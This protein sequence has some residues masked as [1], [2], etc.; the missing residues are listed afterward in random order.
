MIVTRK[1]V[2]LTG[3]NFEQNRALPVLLL[4]QKR[5]GEDPATCCKVAEKSDY[6]YY[7]VL[8]IRPDI[9]LDLVSMCCQLQLTAGGSQ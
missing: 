1:N 4:D 6:Y 7:L 9:E 8:K 2:C 3:R 5:T